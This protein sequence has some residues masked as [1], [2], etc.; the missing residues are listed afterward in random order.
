MK[1][2]SLNIEGDRHLTNRSLP[3]FKRESADVLCLQEVFRQ[4]L[5]LIAEQ[6]NLADYVFV[7]QA[8]VSEVNP[9]LPARG[10]WGLAIF[11]NNLANIRQDFYVG[12]PDLVPEFFADS[13]PNSM[14]RV[15][16]SAQVAVCDQTYQLATTHFTWSGKGEVTDLQRQNFVRLQEKLKLFPELI[17]CGDFNTPRGGELFDTLAKKYRDNIPGGIKTTIDADLHKS[18]RDIQLV[19]DALFTTAHYQPKKVT[20]VAGVS[21][22]MA[23]VA[24]F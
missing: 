8:L 22:H 11:A 19:V 9:H 16:L 1:L 15:L 14:S 10:E 23:V 18:G 5:N 17:L 13:N 7:P 24:E 6:T 3:F 4:D 12:R 20:V 21:D 2:I